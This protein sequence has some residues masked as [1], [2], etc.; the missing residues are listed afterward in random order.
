MSHPYEELVHRGYDALASGDLTPFQELLDPDVVWHVP[1]NNPTAG[2]YHGIEGVMTFIAEAFQ[3]TE[4]NMRFELHDVLANDEH[5]VALQHLSA[6]RGD[7]MLD[8]HD[9]V[10][11]HVRDGKATEIW[12]HSGDQ[13][14]HDAF[15]S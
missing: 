7:R 6:T 5:A 14:A 11:Y 9:V 15:W 2:E 8:A 13:A 1:G 12:F 10:V 4:G 3:R